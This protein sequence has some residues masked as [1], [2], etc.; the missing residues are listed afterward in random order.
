MARFDGQRRFAV[1]GAAPDLVFCSDLGDGANHKVAAS[2]SWTLTLEG[3]RNKVVIR[4][5]TVGE[6]TAHLRN[7][8]LN[9]VLYKHPC[10]CP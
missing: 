6:G 1:G 8:V 10:A 5:A 2:H 9:V 4:Y 7:V 3:G